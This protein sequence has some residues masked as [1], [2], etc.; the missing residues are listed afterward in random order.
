MI[1]DT[2]TDEE[3][4]M[5]IGTGRIL[6]FAKGDLILREGEATNAL[7]LIQS[8]AV[9]V[10]KNLDAER[11]KQLK[12][13]LAGDF[14]G[15][16][17]FLTGAERSADI[18]A[19]QDCQILEIERSDFDE[20]VKEHPAIGLKAYRNIAVELASRLRR[21]NEELKRAIMWALDEMIS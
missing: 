20:L 13:L 4:Q 11:Y 7:Y 21:N 15:D 8:G 17:S 6:N 9:Q 2:L 12:D 5:V 10:R 14:F 3:H 16:M 18:L 19:L 1:F